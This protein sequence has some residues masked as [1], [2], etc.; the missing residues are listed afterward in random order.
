MR[1]GS[2]LGRAVRKSPFLRDRRGAE[3]LELAIVFPVFIIF[4]LFLFEIAYDQFLQTE[5]EGALQLTSYQVQ[6]GNTINTAGSQAFI[7]NDFCPNALAGALNCANLYIRVQ[8]VDPTTCTSPANDFYSATSGALPVTGG[9]LQLGAY[10]GQNNGN[11]MGSV[12]GPVACGGTQTAFCNA[13][14]NQFIILS[15]IYVSPN[16]IGGLLS[17]SAYTYNGS[18]IH[19]AIATTAFYTENFLSANQTQNNQC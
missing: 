13:G 10:Q 3:M 7:N 2:R 17:G 15:A 9:V 8:K 14:P 19:A 6:V 4:L 12:V 11:G 18:L 16:F 1:F 5:L